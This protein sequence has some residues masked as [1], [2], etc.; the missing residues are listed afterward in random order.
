MLGKIEGERRRGLQRM[1]WLDSITNSM[2]FE[3][4]LGD[5]GR[6]R[7]MACC[8]P[9]GG[10]E[11]DTINLTPKTA[12]YLHEANEVLVL[13][14]SKSLSFINPGMIQLEGTQ[15]KCCPQSELWLSS[16]TEMHQYEIRCAVF[17][18]PGR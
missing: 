8:S 9:W 15:E 4:T 3:Q 14:V 11:S 2:E 10:K 6:Q 5:S 1:R 7:S 16:F 12:K 17:T 13:N 18:L